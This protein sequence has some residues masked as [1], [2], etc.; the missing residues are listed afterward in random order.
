MRIPVR[1]KLLDDPRVPI[2]PYLADSS[3]AAPCVCGEPFSA[4]DP[5]V[6]VAGDTGLRRLYHFR[7][8]PMDAFEE[9]DG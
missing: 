8:L 5:A 9:Y 2:P 4:D 6:M 7:C 3:W 1:K